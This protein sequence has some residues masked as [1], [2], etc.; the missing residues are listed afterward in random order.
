MS[1]KNLDFKLEVNE[2]LLREYTTTVHEDSD[3]FRGHFPGHP[4]LPGVVQLEAI[5]FEL[6]VKAWQ[7]LG[8]LQ[9]LRR[10]KFRR[11]IEPNS[12]LRVTLEREEPSRVRFAIHLNGGA[13]NCSSGILC[14]GQERDAS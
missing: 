2:P 7:D 12:V 11:I 8:S 3:Y 14:F 6:S 13:E 1:N 4:V 9:A 10:L 5:V